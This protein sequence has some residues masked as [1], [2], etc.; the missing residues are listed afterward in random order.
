MAS[1]NVPAV[2]P[3][4]PLSA[5]LSQ[6]LVAFTIDLDNEFERQMVDAGFRGISLSVMVWSNLFRFIADQGVAVRELAAAAFGRPERTLAMLGCLERWGYISFD[7]SPANNRPVPLHAHRRTGRL[8]RNG[9]GS[10]R[11]VRSRWLVQ[12]TAKGRFARAAWPPV[13]DAIEG[14]WRERF[15]GDRIRDLRA[16]LQSIV[17]RLDVELPDGLPQHE[18]EESF[19]PRRTSAD[20]RSPLP[21][22]LSKALLGFALEFNRESVAP[23]AL[24]ANVL[25]VVTADGVPVGDLARLTGGSPEMS[26]I[27]WRLKRYVVVE[28]SARGRRIV[29]LAPYGL[30]AHR[31]YP[32]LLASIEAR[33][34][35][36]CG[37]R[38]VGELHA[39]L[40]ALFDRA[41]GGPPL[42]SE[43]LSPPRGG[44]RSGA[45]VAALGA[46]GLVPAEQRR[47]REMAAQAA[48]YIDDPGGNLPH[49]PMWDMTRGF[50]P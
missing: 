13:F 28:P 8:V 45:G 12:P 25:R 16:A 2:E 44:R 41:D 27:G 10:G 40:R 15:G 6:A 21:N 48:A 37:A 22:L 38:I 33:W 36:R 17:N 43:G 26:A 42:I 14:R 1:A 49:Y 34:K 5:L 24:C 31:A 18:D 9:Y 7:P 35:E 39:S 3:R 23:L 11:G 4:L 20:G 46:L 29:R 19:Q 47:T 50:G 30:D 32:R